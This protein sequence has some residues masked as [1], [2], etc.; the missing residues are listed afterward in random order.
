MKLHFSIIGFAAL[1]LTTAWTAPAPSEMN[2]AEVATVTAKEPGGPF[3]FVRTHRQGKGMTTTW[4]VEAE[5]GIVAFTLQKTYEDPTDEY[6]VWEDVT[7]TPCNG[8][9]SYKCTDNNVFPGYV[10]YRVVG[11]KANGGSI[12]SGV[13]TARIVS[14]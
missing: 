1:V 3:S 14:H 4:G 8:S 6:A 10:N 7:T 12:V 2:K 5:Q 11:L 9:R 13:T